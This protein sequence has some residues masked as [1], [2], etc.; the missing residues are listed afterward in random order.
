MDF[1]QQAKICPPPLSFSAGGRNFIFHFFPLKPLLYL[2]KQGAWDFFSSPPAKGTVR[3]RMRMR[4][5]GLKP[6]RE[7]YSLS[8]RRWGGGGISFAKWWTAR[9]L[10][11]WFGWFGWGVT[12]QKGCLV[13]WGG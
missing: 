10:F 7:N 13:G 12:P 1:F 11:G 3:M 6:A 2:G 4:R 9:K 5:A 8:L